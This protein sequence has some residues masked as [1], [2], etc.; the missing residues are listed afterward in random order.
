MIIPQKIITDA[1]PGQ[2][3]V[4]VI[5]CDDRHANHNPTS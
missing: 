3:R 1:A 4:T 2:L 5:R